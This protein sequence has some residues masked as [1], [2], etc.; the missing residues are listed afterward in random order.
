MARRRAKRW[1]KVD[2]FIH[3]NDRVRAAGRNGR[4]VFLYLLCVVYE[5]EIGFA[6]GADCVIPAALVKSNR[7][8]APYL[9][10]TYDEIE[11]GWQ[12]CADP[13]ISLIRRLENGDVEL[14]GWSDD[15]RPKALSGADR[16]AK[17]RDRRAVT[18]R[19]EVTTDVT[20]VTPNV[21]ERHETRHAS[22]ENVTPSYTLRSSGS[23]SLPDPDARSAARHAL[24]ADGRYKS[25]AR[26]LLEAIQSH[27]PAAKATEKQIEIWA[28]AI[29]D[30]IEG[31][32]RTEEEIRAAID[33]AHRNKSDGY[34]RGRAAN[35]VSLYRNL[36]TILLQA[37]EAR[38][39]TAVGPYRVTG[40]E[41]YAHGEQKL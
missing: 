2:T 19:H 5:H 39:G 4:D 17:L 7:L 40:N 29:G 10:M 22:G 32:G 33:F 26:Y 38:A 9:Q 24:P 23:K 18:D 3:E 1:A 27:D 28:H 11:D 37:R 30:A 25:L 13:E 20:G 8:L 35:G 12:S 16:Q 34:W 15:W 14:L 6:P 41:T 31:D 21:T 36:T